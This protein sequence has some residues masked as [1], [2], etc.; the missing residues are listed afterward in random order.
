MLPGSSQCSAPSQGKALSFL[1][2]RIC[3]SIPREEGGRSTEETVDLLQVLQVPPVPHPSPLPP[4]PPTAPTAQSRPVRFWGEG[5][6]NPNPDP[7]RGGDAACR[8]WAVDSTAP[9]G[10]S[11]ESPEHL[12]PSGCPRN[13]REVRSQQNFEARARPPKPQLGIRLYTIRGSL[14]P[15]TS[16]PSPAE[17]ELSGPPLHASPHPDLTI[18]ASCRAAFEKFSRLFKRHRW[19]T[20]LA[21]PR[22]PKGQRAEP[23]IYFLAT[24]S[25]Q[26]RCPS[27]SLRMR[28]PDAP[29]RAHSP[30]PLLARNNE[31]APPATS[32][33]HAQGIP[34]RP[35]RQP[36]R[37]RRP[38]IGKRFGRRGNCHRTARRLVLPGQR[39]SVEA[40]RAL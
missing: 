19:G 24:L 22:A 33:D 27:P 28:P 36:S 13:P 9:N 15:L 12:C 4:T 37:G 3:I 1:K 6:W 14:S 29:T 31:T 10:G 34:G 8:P 23:G 39:P 5:C 25:A 30:V 2:K 21:R 38:P 7:P 16:P 40:A 11:R 26:P 18:A 17:Q 32:A 35:S 20:E